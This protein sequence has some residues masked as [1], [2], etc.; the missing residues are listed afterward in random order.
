MTLPAAKA[1]IAEANRG[2]PFVASRLPPRLVW[3]TIYGFGA[4][5]ARGIGVGLI[6]LSTGR[7]YSFGSAIPSGFTDDR[8]KGW[9][10]AS[11]PRTSCKPMN[12]ERQITK[13]YPLRSSP[14][15]AAPVLGPCTLTEPCRFAPFVP[16]A[17]IRRRLEDKNAPDRAVLRTNLRFAQ[18]SGS[19]T[20]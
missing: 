5:S 9:G 19:Q 15:P 1:C 16:F 14:L 6:E 20:R 10:S 8:S 7:P 13:V 17:R 12:G 18:T 3:P 2:R 11:V 4:P